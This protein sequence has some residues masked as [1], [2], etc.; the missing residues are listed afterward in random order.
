MARSFDP[1]TFDELVRS[2]TQRSAAAELLAI[3]GCLVL[4]WLIVRLLRGRERPVGSVWFGNR[5]VDG[6]LFPVLALALAFAARVTL[7]NTI[8]PA[9]FRV[10]IPILVSLAVIRLSA[11]VLRAT[12]P[13]SRWVTAVERSV[14]W[15]AWIAV[16]LWVTGI[17]PQLLDA[18]DEVRWKVGATQMTLRNLVEGTITASFVLVLA[19]WVSA[20]VERKLLAGSGHDLSIRK[21]IATIVRTLLLFVGLLLALSAVGIDL[22][23][24]S[25]FGGAVGVGLGFGFQKIASNYISGFVILAERSLRIGDMVKVDN[26]E[27]RIT[28]IRTRYTLIRSPNGRQAIVPNET[29]ITQRVENASL[30]DPRLALTTSVL[31]A[32]GTDVRAVQTLLCEAVRPVPRVIDDPAPIVMLSAFTPDGIELTVQFSINDAD[33]GQGNVKSAVNLAVLD[34]LNAAG[35]RIAQPQR[36]LQAGES[37]AGAVAAWG[38]RSGAVSPPGPASA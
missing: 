32:Y 8:R 33:K 35:V 12:F 38:E 18:M 21:M 2:L 7:E 5:I 37:L 10:A 30:A 23:A 31:V 16:V 29:L 25:V 11:R 34:A 13:Q 22:T 1:A 28:D 36:V 15:L 9:V 14:S 19:L 17:S 3:A 26:F 6:V 27:G 24:L 4:A 20:A